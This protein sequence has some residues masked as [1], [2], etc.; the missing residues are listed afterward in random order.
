MEEVIA[1]LTVTAIQTMVVTARLMVTE[2]PMDIRNLVVI[3]L[4][5]DTVVLLVTVRLMVMVDQA[6]VTASPMDM[7]VQAVGTVLPM[8]MVVQAAMAHSINAS[9]TN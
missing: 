6:V 3:N 9:S 5:T 2:A 7:V 1:A 4:H 8:D